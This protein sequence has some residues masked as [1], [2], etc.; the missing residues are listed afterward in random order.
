MNKTAEKKARKKKSFHIGGLFY[1]NKFVMA[2]SSCGTYPVVFM[3]FNNT[4]FSGYWMSRRLLIARVCPGNR[5]EV[6]LR[7]LRGYV[8]KETTCPCAPLKQRI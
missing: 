5:S 8:K 3:A 7:G 4:N 1:N 2:F 6:L